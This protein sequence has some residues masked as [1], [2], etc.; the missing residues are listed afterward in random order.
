MGEAR[1]EWGAAMAVFLARRGVMGVL[2]ATRADGVG[3]A[4]RVGRLTVFEGKVDSDEGNIF[5]VLATTDAV[6]RRHC[7]AFIADVYGDEELPDG[8]EVVVDELTV[9][10][11]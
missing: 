8:V 1:A 11:E 6:A 2:E 9:E 5:R 10:A 4:G 3:H 7:H